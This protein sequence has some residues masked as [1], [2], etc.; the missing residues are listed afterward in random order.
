MQQN[1]PEIQTMSGINFQY[2]SSDR[3]LQVLFQ[4]L[5]DLQTMKTYKRNRSPATRHI[6]NLR[7]R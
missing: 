7:T 1:A 4:S 3:N 5:L 6:L 2:P